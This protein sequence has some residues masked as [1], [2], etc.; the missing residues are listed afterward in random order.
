MHTVLSPSQLP[1]SAV[2]VAGELTRDAVKL[3]KDLPCP[4]PSKKRYI[5]RGRDGRKDQ[6]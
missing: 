2:L 5:C 4:T 1:L 3:E 6:F